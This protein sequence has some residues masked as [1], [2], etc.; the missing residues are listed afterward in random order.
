LCET[1]FHERCSLGKTGIVALAGKFENMHATRRSLLSRVKNPEDHESWKDF[2]DTYSRLVYSVAMKAGLTNTEAEEAMQETFIAL[3]RKMPEFKYDP[4]IGSF[5]NWLIKTTQ[6]KVG[7]QF[8]KRKRQQPA[9]SARG[10]RTEKRTATIDR[11]PD[12]ASL[13]LN[14]VCEVEWRELVFARAVEKLKEQ[15]PPNQ[16][17]IFDLYVLKKW[18][19]RKVATA[20][21]IS[22]GRIYLTKHR[23][24]QLVKREMKVLEETL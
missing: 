13:D 8:R 10:E 20:L 7:D 1:S 18:P 9:G 5:K 21:G 23:L 15:V 19:V 24:A 12:P 3:A 2:F 17:Q 4:A 22:S 14:E 11:I 6:F 16:F